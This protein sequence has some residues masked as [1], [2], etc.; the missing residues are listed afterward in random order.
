MDDS[1]KI[2]DR[3]NEIKDL[4]FVLSVVELRKSGLSQ[5]AIAK[6]LK[7]SNTTINNLLKN[8]RIGEED[9]NHG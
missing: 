9:K 1:K 8:T 5:G 4:L 3:L 7:T 6:I 2:Y